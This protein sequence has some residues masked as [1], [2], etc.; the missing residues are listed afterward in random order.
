VDDRR[1]VAVENESDQADELSPD[2]PSRVRR[3]AAAVAVMSVLVLAL[4]VWRAGPWKGG[5]EPAVSPPATAPRTTAA[6]PS[7]TVAYDAA[8]APFPERRSV[9]EWPFSADSIW[10]LPLG[11]EAELAPIGF[12]Q[13]PNGYVMDTGVIVMSPSAPLRPVVTFDWPARCASDDDEQTGLN[14]PVPDDLVVAP[15]SPDWSGVTPNLAGGVLL[16]DGRTVQELNYVSRCEP[17]GPIGVAADGVRGRLDLFG[18]GAGTGRESWGGHGGSRLSAVGG[19]IRVGELTGPDPIRHVTKIGVD[20]S[21]WCRQEGGRNTYRWPA[22][23]ADALSTLEYGSNAVRE[24]RLGMGSLV[25]IPPDVD[26]TTLGLETL[27]AQ[28]LAWTWQHYG[29]YVVDNTGEDDG[30]GQ[31]AIMVEFGVVAELQE[32]GVDPNTWA[33]QGW[34]DTP[35]NRDMNRLFAQLHEVVNQGPDRPGGGGRPVQPLAPPFVEEAG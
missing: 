17:G 13:P 20:C 19:T 22:L 28:K 34:E 12:T 11:S 15:D 29:A 5:E 7:T 8:A 31:Q 35:W 3:V 9:Y 24:P 16:A 32:V 4:L 23:A 30:W 6:P 21:R 26:L 2:D 33:R 14:L 27:P 10:N 25:A 18:A 1:A